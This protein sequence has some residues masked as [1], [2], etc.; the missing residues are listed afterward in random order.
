[1]EALIATSTQNGYTD[2]DIVEA[3]SLN[4]IRLAHA[5]TLTSVQRFP[6][7][8]VSG[9]RTPDTA[10]DK[11]L[12]V[13]HQYKFAFD[14]DTL[15]QTNLI[16]GEVTNPAGNFV[17]YILR[18]L[19]N[20]EHMLFGVT[21]VTHWYGTLRSNLDAEDVWDV[22]ENC[23][24]YLR[25]DYSTWPVSEIEKRL[26]LP[27]TMTGKQVTESGTVDV[28]LSDPTVDEFRS[29][30]VETTMDGDEPTTTVLA[31]RRFK[32]P[33][34]DLSETLGIQPDI[35]RTQMTDVRTSEDIPHVDAC[36]VDKES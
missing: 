2:G 21:S 25:E 7:D 15:T 17:D 8:A 1:M 27:I 14:N 26:F 13:T 22:L 18:R 10:L 34:W 9:L 24:D 19:M 30:S 29:E 5:Q 11:V 35:A 6:L 31:R 12:A 3:F 16:T 33:Y 4:R 20:S 23:S 28:L 36:I 32:V